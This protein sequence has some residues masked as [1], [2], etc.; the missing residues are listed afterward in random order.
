MLS[1]RYHYAV[2]YWRSCEEWYWIDENN[3]PHIKDSAPES[4]KDSFELFMSTEE[5]EIAMRHYE[6]KCLE[7]ELKRAALDTNEDGGLYIDDT[8]QIYDSFGDSEIYQEYLRRSKLRI[9][10]LPN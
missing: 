4:A 3:M 7:R 9:E 8:Q 2:N 1:L 6:E 10:D 5:T